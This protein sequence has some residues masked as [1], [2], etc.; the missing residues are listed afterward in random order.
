M[1]R[2]LFGWPAFLLAAVAAQTWV[3]TAGLARDPHGY[4]PGDSSVYAM[5]AQSLYRD[6][7]L[8]LLNQH[9]DFRDKA[10]LEEA[11]PALT[12]TEHATEFGLSKDGRM[13]IKQSP[14][15]A[16]AA[17]PFYV[18]FGLIGFLFFNLVVLNL[19]LVMMARLAGDTPAAKVVVLI[20]FLTT[21]LLGYSFNFSPDLAL[22]ALLVGALL[23]G[24]S[25]RPGLAGVLAGLAVSTK[26]YVALLALPVVPVV[27][28]AAD[29]KWAA[30][31]RLVAGGLLGLAPGLAFNTWLFGAPWVSG[32]ERQLSIVNG[33]IGV[34]DHTSRFAF[35]PVEGLR[36]LIFH[37]ELGLWPTAPVWF[38][39]PAAAV[40]LFVPKFA[41]P[42]GRTGAVALIA[43]IGLTLGLFSCYTGALI[44]SIGGNRYMFPA[45]VAG[46]VL[47]AAGAGELFRR[48]GPHPAG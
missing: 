47:M 4:L 12:D 32:Y 1:S 6:G 3:I 28:V 37:P 46:I 2:H 22:C 21:P 31:G 18:V 39:W 9:P 40:I 43:L 27:W 5:A 25:G 48:Y 11:V 16:A 15:L 24:R 36:E 41:P 45:L 34:A 13:T 14:V 42:A 29:R 10:S 17:L 8:D 35:Q 30:L 44:G 38:L 19:L 23:A 26:V 33:Q 7:D 20:G